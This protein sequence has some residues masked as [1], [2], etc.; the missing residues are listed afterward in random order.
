[1]DLTVTQNVFPILSAKFLKKIVY[2]MKGLKPFLNSQNFI[3]NRTNM[4]I[5]L[6][7]GQRL[8]YGIREYFS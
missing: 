4:K 8:L 3:F 6:Q 1:M 5:V 7:I 2:F